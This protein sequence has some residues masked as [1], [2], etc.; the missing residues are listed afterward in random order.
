MPR[1]LESWF[2]ASAARAPALLPVVGRLAE[3]SGVV[4][5]FAPV[6]VMRSEFG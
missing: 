1:R 5:R 4:S 6:I 2:G 3:V